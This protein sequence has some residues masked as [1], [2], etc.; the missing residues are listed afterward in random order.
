MR[1]HILPS[2]PTTAAPIPEELDVASIATVAVTSEAVEHPVENAFDHRRGPGG[3]CWM[4]ATSGE[5]TLLLSFDEPQSIRRISIEVEETQ[6]SRT[7]E[8][9][10]AVSHDSGE[11]YCELMR[12]EF[13]F[14]PADTT[15]ER[16]EW[17][18]A[19]DQVTHLRLVIKPDKG[20][21]PCRASLTSLALG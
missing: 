15:F 1:K 6:T 14:S 2:R 18:V 4:A 8:L 12:Q 7:Q 20:G 5:Q 13:N 17:A 21:G 10:L 9:E 19:I 11:T 16:E 3:S